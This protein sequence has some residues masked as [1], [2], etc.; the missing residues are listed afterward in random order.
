MSVYIHIHIHTY[1]RVCSVPQMA[2]CRMCVFIHTY[3]YIY[4]CIG[5]GRA[6]FKWMLHTY[7]HTYVHTYIHTYIHTYTHINMQAQ[8]SF[9]QM[10]AH[11]VPYV[12]CIRLTPSWHK[13]SITYIHTYIHKYAGS[14][15]LYSNEC[16]S[17]PICDVYPTYPIVTQDQRQIL[18][19]EMD[20]SVCICI[21]ACTY[22]DMHRNLCVYVCVLAH[23]QLQMK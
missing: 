21:C 2:S 15:E 14:G 22:V 16:T 10:S 7:I 18:C 6:L 5:P 8:E 17:R 9:I 20:R 13:T 1:I 11:L 23:D 19:N 12:T 3:I 4:M